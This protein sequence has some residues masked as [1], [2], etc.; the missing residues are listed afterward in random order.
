M[1]AERPGGFYQFGPFKLDV[2]KR[3]LYRSG[4]FVPVTPKVLETLLVLVEQAGQVVTKEEVLQRVW[5]DAFVEE[6]SIS[7][8]IFTLRKILNPHF[9]GESPILT[10]ARRGYRFTA[11]V[12]RHDDEVP[13]TVADPPVAPHPVDERLQDASEIT[14]IVPPRPAR[15]RAIW[16]A[17]GLAGLAVVL[18][19]GLMARGKPDTTRQHRPAVAVLKIKNLSSEP[20]A[21]I[22]LALQET[23]GSELSSGGNLRAIP[24]ESVAEMQRDLSIDSDKTLERSQMNAIAQRLGC[25][26]VLTGSYLSAGGKMRLDVQLTN[27]ATGESVNSSVTDTA[28]K[29]LDLVSRAGTDLRAGIG[30]APVPPSEAAATQAAMSVNTDANRYYFEGL[31]ALRLRDGPQAQEMLSKAIEADPDFALAHSALS[32]TLRIL[33]YD[34]RGAEEAKRAFE[35]SG[36]LRREDQLLIE[37]EYY[38]ASSKWQT[39]TEKYQAL[40]NFFPDNIEYGLKVAEMQWRG[41]KSNDALRTIEQLKA[42]ASN[43]DPRIG[44][45]ECT[46]ADMVGDQPRAIRVAEET[47]NKASASGSSLLLARVRI[48]QGIYA[49]RGG[50][51]EQAQR[52]FAEARQLFQVAGETGGVADAIRW[53]AEVASYQGDF[54]KAKAELDSAL[55][56]TTRMAYIRLTT[57]IQLLQSI[58]WRRLGKFSEATAAAEA[59]LHSA[60]EAANLEAESRAFNNIGLIARSQGQYAKAREMY[61]EGAQA[62]RSAANENDYTVAVNNLAALDL[63]QGRLSDAQARLE[64]IL[65]I[66]RKLGRPIYV[67]V[68]LYNLARV[69]LQEGDLEAAQKFNAE[70][71]QILQSIKDIPDLALCHIRQVE[72]DLAQGRT[73]EARSTV[74]SLVSEVKAAKLFPGELATLAILQVTLGN[75]GQAIQTLEMARKTLQSGTFGP[76][77]SIGVAIAEARIENAA[78]PRLALSKLAR[79]Q[80]DAQKFGLMLRFEARLA[81]AEIQSRQGNNTEADKLARDATEAGLSL[82][83]VKARNVGSAILRASG[84]N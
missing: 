2:S 71:C 50:S 32:N 14:V 60:Q 20:D 8:N 1:P 65:P 72:I 17:L 77:D 10:V 45:I 21:W 57:E 59:S 75:A 26:F 56:L 39:A 66:D 82:F 24:V 7:N 70:G 41:N 11:A 73:E 51:Y 22:A 84:S 83:A 19:I 35:R 38:E 42:S 16:V 40:W 31:A 29:L 9:E 53:D 69:R 28:D 23:L 78:S 44:L 79:A 27:L 30:V 36:K 33:G 74:E 61:T 37:A 63:V 25:D 80:S 48:K 76:E 15:G 68:H 12:A 4:E 81:M 67:G 18:A 64:E 47:A 5:P 58:V 55:A 43:P 3:V 6:G 52:F 34:V 13:F 49:D 46:V 54:E 62:A